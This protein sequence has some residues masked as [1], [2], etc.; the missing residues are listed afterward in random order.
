VIETREIEQ[1]LPALSVHAWKER[2]RMLAERGT[3]RPQ[4]AEGA[5]APHEHFAILSQG[6]RMECT[7]RDLFK[8]RNRR[9]HAH[10]FYPAYIACAR[11]HTHTH[12]HMYTTTQAH[13][14]VF[15][16]RVIPKNM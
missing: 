9:F 2:I 7:R 8:A 14:F 6:C 1:S 4:A 15:S 16:E 11:A 3:Q 12:T 10:L 5:L 13:T